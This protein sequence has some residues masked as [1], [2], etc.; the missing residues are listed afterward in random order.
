MKKYCL[1]LDLHD[2]PTLIAEYITHHQNVWPEIRK[3]IEAAGIK[4]LEI[5]NIGNRLIMIIEAEA[6]FTFEEKAKLDAE[7]PKVQE[8]E[9]LMWKFQKA[10]PQAKSGEKWIVMEKIFQL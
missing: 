2:D 3:S 1:A 6:H 7:N 4:N 8:W 9:A 10:L 5:Y